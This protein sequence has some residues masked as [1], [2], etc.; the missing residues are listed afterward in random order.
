[1][2][3]SHAI[4][5]YFEENVLT[6][7]FWPGFPPVTFFSVPW[8]KIGWEEGFVRL[9]WLTETTLVFLFHTY[10]GNTESLRPF[11]DFWPAQFE[12]QDS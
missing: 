7:G 5:N 10:V 6:S 11:R 8:C 4:F 3:V 2:T 12:Q 1:M 9:Y